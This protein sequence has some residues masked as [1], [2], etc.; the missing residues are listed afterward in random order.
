MRTE[1]KLK[2]QRSEAEENK[3]Y[4]SKFFSYMSILYS[5]KHGDMWS[6]VERKLS[7]TQCRE[8]EINSKIWKGTKPPFST[9]NLPR[10]LL[11]RG[12]ATF[13]QNGS[14][15]DHG[16]WEATFPSSQPSDHQRNQPGCCNGSRYHF[17]RTDLV[18]VKPPETLTETS[19]RPLRA[20]L[21]ISQ[22]P[23]PPI[24]SLLIPLAAAGG[25]LFF[26]FA[27][28]TAIYL[29]ALPIAAFVISAATISAIF[30]AMVAAGIISPSEHGFA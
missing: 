30:A 16:R 27:C 17:P 29:G 24:V 10:P 20:L 8:M 9:P 18:S 14:I 13:S 4:K 7:E 28:V 23:V 5:Q 22:L 15:L 26:S 6:N 3:A 11:T 25:F 21:V 12:R 19:R 1:E 2:Q